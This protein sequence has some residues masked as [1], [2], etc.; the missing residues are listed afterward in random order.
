M[1]H[2]CRTKWY[3][4]SACLL[5]VPGPKRLSLFATYLVL[6]VLL[7]VLGSVHLSEWVVLIWSFP[8][9]VY[10]VCRVYHF[11]DHMVENAADTRKIVEE[12]V[13]CLF[14]GDNMMPILHYIPPSPPCRAIMLLGRIININFDL[15]LV[16][17]MEGEQLKQE[18]IQVSAE[19]V[20]TKKKQT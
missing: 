8:R 15:K 6:L 4:V 16:N 20:T 3:S 9:V 19:C 14:R 18:F 2:R 1:C 5:C 13:Y 11:I 10:V 12:F 17:L 7:L